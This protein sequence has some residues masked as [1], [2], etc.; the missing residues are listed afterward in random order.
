MFNVQ[1][2]MSNEFSMGQCSHTYAQ[3]FIRQTVHYGVA[4]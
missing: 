3:S 1:Y 2:S 4:R